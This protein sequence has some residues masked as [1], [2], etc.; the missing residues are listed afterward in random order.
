MIRS[1]GILVANFAKKERQP[2]GKR[3][4]RVGLGLKVV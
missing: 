3:N 1:R 4:G 2:E